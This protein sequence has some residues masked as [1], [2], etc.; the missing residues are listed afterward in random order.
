MVKGKLEA[1]FE[2]GTEGVIWSLY[3]DTKEGYEGLHCLYQGDYLT[4]FD[5]EDKS[6]VVWEGNIDL[7]YERNYHPYPMNPQYGQQA[8]GGM[9][10]H[11]IQRDVEPDTW[12]KWFFKQYPAEVIKSEIGH[13]HRC[14][15]SMISGHRWDGKGSPWNSIRDNA[16][17]IIRFNSGDCYKYKDVDCDTYWAF[18]QA[19]SL[20]K[21]FAANIKNKFEAVKLELPKPAPKQ[22]IVT[23]GWPFPTHYKP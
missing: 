9:W 15:S 4:I 10:V 17:L 22:P 13:M 2:T 19:E 7:E 14:K 1:F 11:G 12:G 3:D 5:P 8:V 21:Y 23:D 18:E 20:G 6:K 16:N